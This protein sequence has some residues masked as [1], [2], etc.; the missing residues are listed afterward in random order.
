MTEEPRLDAREYIRHAL[1]TL[2]YRGAKVVRGAPAEFAA[3]KIGGT[4]RTPLEILAHIGDLFE[5]ASSLVRGEEV[6]RDY[7]P[8]TWDEEVE[9]FFR[10]LGVL[11]QAL[12]AS[13]SLRCPWE[14]LFQGP[15][16]DALTHIG[17]LAMLRRL[18]ASPVRGENYFRA[19]IAAGRL[20][21]DQAAPR[22]EFD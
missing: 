15:V 11:D 7:S 1:G 5:W 12:A 13:G 3:L 20:G 21:A 14:R 22:R 17:Q 16:A 9:R 8:N 10:T 19:E 4:S 18:A 6:W 2:A